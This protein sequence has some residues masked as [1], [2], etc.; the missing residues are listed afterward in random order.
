MCLMGQPLSLCLIVKCQIVVVYAGQTHHGRDSPWSCT[1]HNFAS[2]DAADSSQAETA[3]PRIHA[4]TANLM[5][6]K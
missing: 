6:A 5:P 1:E 4:A 2:T 3:E